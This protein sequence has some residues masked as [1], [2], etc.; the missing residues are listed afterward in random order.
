MKKKR[1]LSLLLVL[2]LVFSMTISPQT[3]FA[4]SPVKISQM[5]AGSVVNFAG[6]P[7]TILDPAEGYMMYNE[8]I[9]N[10]VFDS[11]NTSAFNPYD[12]NNI[13][14][15]LN[16][17]FYNSLPVA[18]SALIQAKSWTI[19]KIDSQGVSQ[20][21][22]SV[23]C[24]VGILSY[25]EAV[26]YRQYLGNISSYNLF[27]TRSWYYADTVRVLTKD[28]S[29]D[30]KAATYGGVQVLP[31]I[32]LSPDALVLSGTVLGGVQHGVSLSASPAAGGTVAGEGCYT[33]G[34]PVTVTATVNDGYTFTNWTKNG[35]E[36]SKSLAYS[37]AQ[38]SD[39][40]SLVANF[41]GIPHTVA[42]S[43]ANT[44]YGTVSGGGSSFIVGDTVT[45]TAIPQSG[46][47]LDNWT[48]DGKIVSVSSSYT[49]VQ[50]LTDRSLIANFKPI[51]AGFDILSGLSVGSIVNFGG[52]E[53]I[54]LNP[55]TG[56]MILKVN[57]GSLAY[58]NELG[59]RYNPSRTGNVAYYLNNDFLNSLYAGD[60]SL[61]QEHTW[62]IGAA[63]GDY[64]ISVAGENASTTSCKVGLLSCSEWKVYKDGNPLPFE[65][66]IWMITPHQDGYVYY[67]YLSARSPFSWMQ[68]AYFPLQVRPTIYLLPST[69]VKSN[70]VAGGHFNTPAV[71]GI[72]PAAGPES[73]GGQVTISG[74]GFNGA[75][76]VKFGTIEGTGLIVI[77]DGSLTVTPPAGSG[78]VDV[79]IT[80][81]MGTSAVSDNARYTYNPPQTVS[82]TANPASGGTV[83]GGG[84]KYEVDSVTVT[85][86]PNNGYRFLNWTEAGNTV[87]TVE[88]YSFTMG[89]QAVSLTANFEAIPYSIGVEQTSH[90]TVA[91]SADTATVGSNIALT[92]QPEDGYRLKMLLLKRNDGTPD[93]VITG[94][95]FSMPA[96][97][98][99]ISAEFEIIP[100][101]LSVE[102]PE[103]KVYTAGNYLDFNVKY[104][105]AVIVD[106][107]GG[108]PTIHV[109]LDKTV[110]QAVYQAVYEAEYF[111]GSG[112]DILSFRYIVQNGD[113][114]EDG[115]E[116]GASIRLNSGTIKDTSDNDALLDLANVADT[117]GI[118]ID[119]IPPDKLMIISITEDAGTSNSDRVTNDTT[120]VISGAAE[121]NSTVEV[122][123]DGDSIGTAQ[124]DSDGSWSLDYSSTELTEG[125]HTIQAAATDKAGNTGEL[126]D[127]FVVTIDTEAPLAPSAPMLATGC[128]T[129]TAGDDNITG[130][131]TLTFLGTAGANDKIS[132]FRNGELLGNTSADSNGDWSL[133]YG[134][135]DN[136][137]YAITARITDTAGNISKDSDKLTIIV[138]KQAPTAPDITGI[139][140]DTGISGAD[141]ITQDDTLLFAGSAEAHSSVDVY[142]DGVKTGSAAANNN[143]SWTYDSSGTPLAEGPHTIAAKAT[144]AAGNTSS[145]SAPCNVSID[146][147]SPHVLSVQIPTDGKYPAGSSLDFTVTFDE[148]VTVTGI[149]SIGLILDS[150]INTGA[151]YLSG[152]GTNTLVFRYAA[153]AGE[154]DIDGISV[155]ENLI[156]SGA[157]ICDAAGNAAGLTLNGIGNTNKILIDGIAP[158]VL[159]VTVPSKATYKSGQNLDFTISFSEELAVTAPTS[160][161]GIRIG[162]KTK[163]AAF[164]TNSANT[165]TYRYV[166]EAGDSGSITLEQL[167]RNTAELKDLAGNAAVLTLNNIE[168][169]EGVLVDN[170]GPSITK[171]SIAANNTYIDITFNE[172]VYGTNDG[173]AALSKDSLKLVFTKNSGS[174]T[175]I[176][177]NSIKKNDSTVETAASKL[178]GGEEAVRVFLALTGTYAN[179]S[180]TVEITPASGASIFDAIGNVMADKQTTGVMALT[181]NTPSPHGGGSGSGSASASTPAPTT[182]TPV[183]TASSGTAVTATVEAIA[184]VD[185]EGNASA[186]V[187]QAQVSQAISQSVAEAAKQGNGVSAQVEIKVTAPAGA[188]TVEIS[189]PKAAVSLAAEGKVGALTVSTPVASITFD[190]KALDTI[191]KQAAGAVKITAAKA[192]AETLSEEIKRTIGDRPVYSFSVTS[193]GK[194]ISQFGGNATVSIPYTPRAGEDINAIV[195]YYINAE[196]KPEI[197]SNCAYDPATGTITFSTNHFSIYA[198]GYNKI[199]FKD[200]AANAWYG[201]AVSFI[202]ARGITSGT[203]EGNYSPEEKLTRG[204][205]MVMVMRS[206]GIK[207]DENAKDN[208]ADSGSTYYT[209]YL[210]AAKRLR[211]SEGIG[212]NMFAPEKEITRQ[213]MFTL[214]YNTLKSIGELPAS[215]AEK[216]LS[217][218]T[219]A[220]SIDSWAKDAMAFFVEA[221]TVSGS[222]GKL[223]PTDTTDR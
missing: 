67:S 15:Y 112:T 147:V 166:I 103:A 14:Y 126:S 83:S 62:G 35:S 40:I 12:T 63:T 155:A 117:T 181:N 144:D 218:F 37:F 20:V 28:L 49:F 139:Q 216:A 191:D 157:A 111:A 206:Y 119:T 127:S 205:F 48:E 173:T 24:R 201:N 116:L 89:A 180:E 129:G 136:G 176:R 168:D 99:T 197:V 124:A 3:A 71:T 27:W 97:N 123:L 30:N 68:T 74:A 194:T 185:S 1:F 85:A 86:T 209:G 122:F 133:T 196:G 223:N 21:V 33:A 130:A 132:I 39:N 177:I 32:Y 161:L 98:V 53:W 150:N 217:D 59:Q 29:A 149:P 138:D 115:I 92:V 219:D 114:D 16:N 4:A 110:T 152:S 10:L 200:V 153:E 82:L 41:A 73:G 65:N 96:A 131:D 23:N 118:Q 9:D 202:A 208:F 36:V 199:S 211:I 141:G 31:A 174:L 160:A 108:T 179:G 215:K 143:G 18:D 2:T 87:S 102:V 77:G 75:T 188:K 186:T 5:A 203:E 159:S 187:T 72:S 61:V 213:E 26:S 34:A 163:Q 100:Q 22:S 195:I 19:E 156:C 120:L 25:Q 148:A 190:R 8:F 13:G 105:T 93:T 178:S 222:S 170:L 57:L 142:I 158:E 51:P 210:A 44:D 192:E 56:Y 214:L 165:L 145:I 175:D 167:M 162:G 169:T 76:S 184:V 38:N 52:K 164:L 189:L 46:Y 101:V 11:D 171:A 220:N 47:C 54:L 17:N 69:I 79:T 84:L 121:A 207:A 193:G 80:G 182:I 151:A 140:D 88:S 134:Q 137:T 45:V 204:Q 60:R 94:T 64:G 55:Q 212:N 125:E 58:D 128:D 198:V 7:W 172:G 70:T 135:F 146:K 183:E 154:Q 50:G 6:K 66:N 107:A 104:A 221:G 91:T 109:D 106:T 78:T 95:S 113:F 81:P 43:S 90:G 42:V